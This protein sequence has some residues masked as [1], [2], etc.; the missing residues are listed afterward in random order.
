MADAVVKIRNSLREIQRLTQ[1]INKLS[2]NIIGE[3][4]NAA[5]LKNPALLLAAALPFYSYLDVISKLSEF[6]KVL[7]FKN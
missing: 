3:R 1:C 2:P 5:F 6:D 7:L 4:I